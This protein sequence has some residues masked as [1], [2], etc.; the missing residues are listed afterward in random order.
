MG[1]VLYRLHGAD[2]VLGTEMTST[3]LLGN[4]KTL[5]EQRNIEQDF[6]VMRDLV[7]LIGIHPLRHFLLL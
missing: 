6:R 2:T 7:I 5:L 1:C 3:K 4:E